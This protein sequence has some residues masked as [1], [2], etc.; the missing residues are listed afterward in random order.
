VEPRI[1]LLTADRFSPWNGRRPDEPDHIWADLPLKV[2]LSLLVYRGEEI[3]RGPGEYRFGIVEETEYRSSDRWM[4]PVVVL[5]SLFLAT[6]FGPRL[7][8]GL[9][10]LL[11]ASRLKR[12]LLRQSSP[13]AVTRWH[14]VVVGL[15]RHLRTSQPDALVFHGEF[16]AWGIAVVWACRRAG[17]RCV[18]HQHYAMPADTPLYR[19][20]ER[21]GRFAPDGL[22]CVSRYQQEL[23]KSLPIPVGFGG[24]RRP[25]WN[26]QNRSTRGKERMG[27]LLIVP[28]VGDTAQI[29]REIAER[30]I[31]R[32]HV[33]PHP[34]RLTGWD[35]A[36][37]ELHDENLVELLGRFDAVITS[38][39]S[40]TVTLTAAEQPFIK[41]RGDQPDGTC[42][43][44]ERRVFSSLREILDSL[45]EGVRI[46]HITSLGCEHNL[47]DPPSREEYLSEIQQTLTSR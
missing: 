29:Q 5:Q 42:Q 13:G 20:I 41:M 36:N 4:I 16:D 23:W 26:L 33:R 15:S 40:P 12:L 24:S 1:V 18:A 32:F 9:R 30:P 37:V 17:V 25:I 2:D 11:V 8:L 31:G 28:S 38:S 46:E 19:R 7:L 47:T 6:R 45:A 43:C 44:G 14:R 22:L 39:P 21:L 27:Q 35:I 3:S 10:P 34:G